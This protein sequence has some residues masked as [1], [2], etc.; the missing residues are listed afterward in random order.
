MWTFSCTQYFVSLCRT[1]SSKKIE[2][3]LENVQPSVA[4]CSDSTKANFQ[5]DI[6]YTVGWSVEFF[7]DR[8]EQGN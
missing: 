8:T 1:K 3:I 6:H 5:L 7:F 4:A 2:N